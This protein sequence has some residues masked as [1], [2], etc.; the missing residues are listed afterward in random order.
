MQVQQQKFKR[1]NSGG[2]CCTLQRSASCSLFL[3]FGGLQHVQFLQEW[4]PEV[5]ILH[6]P[7]ADHGSRV[8]G[9]LDQTSHDRLLLL[10]LLSSLQVFLTGPTLTF[11]ENEHPR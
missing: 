6:L 2:T 3:S 7:K 11:L 8:F 9:G 4:L 10:L 1:N 5:Y